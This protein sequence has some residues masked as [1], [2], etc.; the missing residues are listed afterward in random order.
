MPHGCSLPLHETSYKKP[1]MPHEFTPKWIG[2]N[3]PDSSISTA[4]H[5]WLWDTQQDGR[6][7]RTDVWHLTAGTNSRKVTGFSSK[8]LQL[9]SWAVSSDVH[10]VFTYSLCCLSAAPSIHLGVV[11]V[12]KSVWVLPTVTHMNSKHD[13]IRFRCIRKRIWSY[14]QKSLRGSCHGY[15]WEYITWR[16]FL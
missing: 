6:K 16:I 5:V 8:F 2:L 7:G 9:L 10:Y 13:I 14:F 1:H 12:H 3:F 4:Q 15:Q 11:R